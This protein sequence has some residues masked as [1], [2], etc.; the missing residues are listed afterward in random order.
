MKTRGIKKAS[1][2]DFGGE[3]SFR[4]R[5]DTLAH[6]LLK[7]DL[8]AEARKIEQLPDA[9]RPEA[10]GRSPDSEATEWGL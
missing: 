4:L 8:A 5:R 3:R 9:A 10:G 7:L 1:E 2:R 6:V